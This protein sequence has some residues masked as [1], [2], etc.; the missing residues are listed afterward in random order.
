MTY[1]K[2][3]TKDLNST[4]VMAVLTEWLQHV[5]VIG[6]C[7]DRL[8]SDEQDLHHRFMLIKLARN[9]V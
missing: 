9:R 7:S 3:P 6:S 4:I 1:K 8:E 5:L 2:I